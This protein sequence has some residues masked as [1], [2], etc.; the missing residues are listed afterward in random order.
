MS[1]WRF[2]WTWPLSVYLWFTN[3]F[4][5]ERTRDH[6]KSI[7]IEISFKMSFWW[8]LY[9]FWFSLWRGVLILR[10]TLYMCVFGWS[11]FFPPP[12]QR[13][14]DMGTWNL[15]SYSPRRYLN[16]FFS[17]Q[18]TWEKGPSKNWC[19][20]WISAYLLDCLVFYWFSWHFSLPSDFIE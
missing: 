20:K 7:C 5:S 17:K 9:A 4:L 6:A 14:K 2:V 18:W 11:V 1:R 13:K 3:K 19:V 16:T 8:V 10:D 15:V 12:D